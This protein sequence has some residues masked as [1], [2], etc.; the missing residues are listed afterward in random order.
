MIT[1]TRLDLEFA[2]MQI[3]QADAG[4]LPIDTHEAPEVQEEH[5][6]LSTDALHDDDD[7]NEAENHDANAHDTRD[8]ADHGH[9]DLSANDTSDGHRDGSLPMI[10]FGAGAANSVDVSGND[11]SDFHPDRSGQVTTFGNSVV[12]GVHS[13]ANDPSNGQGDS[14]NPVITL[15]GG[16][17]TFVWNDTFNQG[18]S[19]NP[20]ITLGNSAVDNALNN[21]PPDLHSD[22]PNPV[23]TLGG[24]IDTFVWNDTFNQGGSA[25]PVITLGNSAGDINALNNNPPDGHSDSSNPVITLSG[26][27]NT[28]VSGDTFNQG[29]SANPVITLGDSTVDINALNNNP[30]DGHSD[31]SNPVITFGSGTDTFVWS[32]TFSHG[33]GANH[34]AA[35]EGFGSS[36]SAFFADSPLVQGGEVNG[37]GGL[38]DM[39]PSGVNPVAF[40]APLADHWF[41]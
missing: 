11:L 24:G 16:I 3:L 33:D 19:V 22:S 8:G 25:N 38:P 21:S 2:P 1:F 4:Q 10:T 30:P 7:S 35:D 40:M 20:V 18:G 37:D 17:D 39:T 28:F 15:D 13:L 27:I 14:P 6:R 29:G 23:I 31:S 32:D 5:Q 41:L 12:D 26:G 36:L 34:A 9:Q